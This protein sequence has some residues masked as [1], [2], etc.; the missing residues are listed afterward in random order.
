MVYG[1]TQSSVCYLC[2][3]C[4]QTEVGLIP[5]ELQARSPA[6]LPL[7]PLRQTPASPRPPN[8]CCLRVYHGEGPSQLRHPAPAWSWRLL[9]ELA[10]FRQVRTPRLSARL[11]NL[12]TISGWVRVTRRLHDRDCAMGPRPGTPQ[13]VGEAATAPTLSF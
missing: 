6:Q 7:L 3:L 8:R 12:G 4:P 11:G 2:F 1:R 13:E 10:C 9:R 5:E